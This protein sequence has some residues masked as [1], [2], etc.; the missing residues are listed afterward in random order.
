MINWRTVKYFHPYEFSDD[1][2][3]ALPMLIYQLDDFRKELESRIFPSPV[4]G[5]LV[6]F[7]SD[8]TGSMHYSDRKEQLSKAVDVFAEGNAADNF[9]FALTCQKWGGVGVYLDTK[10]DNRFWPMMHLDMRPLGHKFSK[11]A[12]LFWVRKKGK[13]YYPQVMKN[14]NKFLGKVLKKLDKSWYR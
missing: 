7:D 3:F 12:T 13:Y 11:K 8:S 14:G 9:I 6:R 4:A 5:S 2:R 1:T 10:Y